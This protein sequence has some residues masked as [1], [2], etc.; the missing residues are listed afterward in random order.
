MPG[1]DQTMTKNNRVRS[2]LFILI[3]ASSLTTAA[4]FVIGW[5][6]TRRALGSEGLL[7]MSVAL[8][9]TFLASALGALP[10][11][12]GRDR[13]PTARH[14]RVMSAMALRMFITLTVFLGLALSGMVALKPLAVWTGLSYLALLGVETTLAV[15]FVSRRE[16]A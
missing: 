11:A 8:G 13:S 5:I 7:A 15:R 6:P 1:A 9:V 10:I 3:G 12:L 16:A 14:L 4:L 2:D